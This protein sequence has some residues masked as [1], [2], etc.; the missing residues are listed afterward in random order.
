MKKLLFFIVLILL[1]LA[2]SADDK[3][4]FTAKAPNTIAMGEQFRVTFSIN[5]H[6]AKDFR[7]PVVS[8]F[9][10]LIGPLRSTSLKTQ[11]IN[12]KVTQTNS[13]CFTYVMMAKRVGTFTIPVAS[14]SAD[15][16]I[17][18]SNTLQIK[19]LSE[20]EVK[21]EDEK[22]KTSVFVKTD[23]SKTAP[24]LY[25][26]I[27]LTYKLYTTT[28][29]IDSLHGLK[30]DF[31][32]FGVNVVDLKDKKWEQE[33]YM[34]KNYQTCTVAQYILYPWR[35]G[36]IELSPCDMEVFLKKE[37][38]TGEDPFDAFFN[39]GN[40]KQIKKKVI[41][42]GG[43]I[44][45]DRL[46]NQPDG[47]SNIIGNFTITSSV[48]KREL[49][50]NDTFVFK[51]KITGSGN[52]PLVRGKL[53]ELPDAFECYE[54]KVTESI[55]VVKGKPVV[56]RECE[57]LIAAR[58]KGMYTIMPVE[59]IYFDVSSNTYRTLQTPIYTIKITASN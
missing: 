56:E 50:V 45:V 19:V 16:K 24:Y 28:L 42:P 29:L 53:P 1:S 11:N 13:I 23:I 46:R 18:H 7:L 49:R 27:V 43:N 4:V 26:A 36:V 59:Y 34:G 15:G 30:P 3:V 33:H 8:G 20:S 55:S 57:Y 47:F 58:K 41:C 12:G 6:T 10:V 38:D 52:L 54:P 39:K 22:D 21:K 25:E 48:S 37:T 14:V 40:Y 35:T 17:I 9:E 5:A 32:E 31:S 44:F 51:M 2:V